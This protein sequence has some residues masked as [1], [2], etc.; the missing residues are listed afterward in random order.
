MRDKTILIA[1]VVA[2]VVSGLINGIGSVKSQDEQSFND[3][4]MSCIE[5]L[6][7]TE[8]GSSHNTGPAQIVDCPGLFTGDG[9]YCLCENSNPCTE[10]ICQ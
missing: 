10:I 1:C 8:T 2:A 6:S 7:S 3:F 9:K 5:A 4:Q